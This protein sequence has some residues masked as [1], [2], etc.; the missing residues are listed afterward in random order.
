MQD[1]VVDF[2]GVQNGN[3]ASPF[4]ESSEGSFLASLK[5]LSQDVGSRL[6]PRGERCGRI[7]YIVMQDH[8]I[9]KLGL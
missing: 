4:V 5:R 6:R 7:I 2:C 9:R 3:V 8:R 1:D